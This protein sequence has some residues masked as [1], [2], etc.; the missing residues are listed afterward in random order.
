MLPI[1]K[2]SV[3]IPNSFSQR[4]NCA[5]PSAIYCSTN[6]NTIQLHKYQRK[7]I[8]KFANATGLVL[9]PIEDRGEFLAA[10]ARASCSGGDRFSLVLENDDFD[11]VS[12]SIY[13]KYQKEIHGED[14]EKGSGVEGFIRFLCSSPI[15]VRGF[16]RMVLR[17][18]SFI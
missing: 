2:H 7:A 17:A 8:R 12:Y 18:N 4:I 11:P 6:C 10:F 5:F 1:G 9:P 14:V 13:C 3:S 15:K 16:P